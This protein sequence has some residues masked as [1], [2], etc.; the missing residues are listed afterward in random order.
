[1]TDPLAEDDIDLADRRVCAS[2]VGDEFL[3]GR[4]VR[5]GTP[6]ECYYCRQDDPA[7]PLATFAAWLELAMDQHFVRTANEPDGFE[8]AMMKD[9]EG[10]YSWERGG[11][12]AADVL[13]YSASIEGGLAADVCELLDEKS[14]TFDAAM[15]G[16][17]TPY[18]GDA[19][20][21]RVRPDD[22]S[23][24]RHWVDFEQ[25]LKAEA[26]FFNSKA[27]HVLQHVFGAI[28]SLRTKEDQPVVRHFGPGEAIDHLF[29]GRVFQSDTKLEAALAKP[30]EELGP[31]PMALARAGRMNAA[32]VSVFYG[33]LDVGTAISEIRPPTGS[34]VV[35][36]RFDIIRPLRL[37]DVERLRSVFVANGSLFDPTYADRLR[38]AQFLTTVGHRIERP[39]MPD[40]EPF[41]YLPTQALADFLASA[42]GPDLDGIIYGSAQS[43]GDECNVVLFHKA[44][45][46]ESLGLPRGAKIGS[47]L[48]NWD[49]D[50]FEV[51]YHVHVDLPDPSIPLS[52]DYRRIG[53]VP[54]T[55]NRIVALRLHRHSMRV[56]DVL[57][58]KVPTT[59]SVV[60]WH[61]SVAKASK[62]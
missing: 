24:H 22:E 18:G 61:E 35:V 38:Q 23:L 3:R 30:V 58:R 32:G 19:H 29:R 49:E 9:P 12:P 37:L 59:E 47:G 44:A 42:D 34:R 43:E 62:F 10:S 13:A 57:P 5:E 39:V 20:Y 21:S 2:C 11:E 55:D 26:R 6:G 54:V 60:S 1:M 53:S 17:E 46:V 16:E 15:S 33:A 4:I 8:Y 56:H 27:S 48:G 28:D 25:S 14:D 45:R 41:E 50:G 7:V 52:V 51:D 40:D 36:A 31:P